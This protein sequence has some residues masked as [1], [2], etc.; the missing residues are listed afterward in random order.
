M[1]V[2]SIVCPIAFQGRSYFGWTQTVILGCI[3]SGLQTGSARTKN[4][5]QIATTGGGGELAAW[6]G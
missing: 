1:L 3:A 4:V 6:D 2:L 5:F